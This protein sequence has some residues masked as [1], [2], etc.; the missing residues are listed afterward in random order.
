LYFDTQKRIRNY[1]DYEVVFFKKHT[2]LVLLKVI[3][4]MYLRDEKLEGEET[5]HFPLHVSKNRGFIKIIAKPYAITT[6][7]VRY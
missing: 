3:K 2:L 4:R 7:Q 1:C 5:K 6:C